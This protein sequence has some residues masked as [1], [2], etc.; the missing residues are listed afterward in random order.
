MHKIERVQLFSNSKEYLKFFILSSLLFCFSLLYEYYNYT[1]LHEFDSYITHAT[2]LQQ[3]TKTK[4]K[5]NGKEKSYQILKLKSDDGFT[6]YTTASKNTPQLLAKEI[7]VEFY[8]DKIDFLAYL[9]NFFAFSKIVAIPKELTNKEKLLTGLS[10]KHKDED[11]AAIYKALFLAIP[12]PSHLQQ[13]FANLG[14]SHLVALSGFHLSVL[15]GILFFLLKYPYMLL[16]SHYFPY[17]SKNRDLFFIIAFILGLYLLFVAMP[18]SLLRAYAMFVVVFVLYDRGVELLSMQTLF[19][20]SIVLV[21]LFPKLLFS[22]GF[23]LSFSG[24]FYIFL[25]LHYFSNYSKVFQ[26]VVLPFWVYLMMLPYSLYLFGNF[27]LLHPLSILWTT[28]FSLFYPLTLFLHAIGLGDLL[29]GVLKMF[30]C[31][32]AHAAKLNLAKEWFY[33]HIVLSL[34]SLYKKELLLLLLFEA[35]SASVYAVY[36]VAEF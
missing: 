14:I 33:G 28:L 9:K 11:I 2:V 17:R 34:L 26:F 13:T 32:D 22:V 30:L 6:F 24:V 23:F 10:L 7:T 12:L 21:V 18:P 19:V 5:P 36:Y 15:F 1:K 31:I 20:S 25:F 8:T 27:S 29:D 3:Y 16:Q 4:V 35:F